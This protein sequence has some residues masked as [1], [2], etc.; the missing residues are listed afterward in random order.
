MPTR[1][2]A[3]QRQGSKGRA[4]K[5][6]HLRMASVLVTVAGVRPS[7]SE[8]DERKGTKSPPAGN[9][10]FHLVNLPKNTVRTEVKTR[11]MSIPYESWSP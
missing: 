5:A 2:E 1:F 11:N 8:S 3:G 9:L 6:G 10:I 7:L 4:A